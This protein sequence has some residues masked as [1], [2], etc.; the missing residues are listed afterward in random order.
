MKLKFGALVVDGRGKVGGHVASKN[1]AGAYLRTKVT[2]SN[3]QT[4]AQT[5][6]RN[7]L[8]QFSQGWRSLTVA[9]RAAWNSAVTNFATTNVF[10]DIK[11]PSGLQLYIK[12]NSNLAEVGVAAISVPPLPA[13]VSAITTFAGTATAGTPTFSL[14]YTPTPVPANTS[15]IIRATTQVSPGKSFV[16]NL[17][18]GVTTVAAAATSPSNILT[19]YTTRYGSL[20]AGQKIGVEV[21]A[22]NTVTGQKGTPVTISIIV[23]A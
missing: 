11:N 4:S 16:K 19:A 5:T 7:R 8:T 22:I 12:L 3:P 23:G 1:R 20:V 9:Q 21:I 18:R 15:L 13:A 17:F 14:T 10:G 6:V 2:P